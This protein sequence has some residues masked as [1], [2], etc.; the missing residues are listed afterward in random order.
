MIIKIDYREKTLKLLC[1]NELVNNK[2]SINIQVDS[3]DLPLGDAILCDDDGNE[4]LMIERKTLHDLAASI[5]DGRYKEQGY[6]LQLSTFHNHNIYY[7][8]EGSLKY[9][10]SYTRIDKKA[11]LSSMVSISHFKGFSLHRTNDIQESAEWIVQL[12]EKIGKQKEIPFYKNITQREI[13]DNTENTENTENIENIENTENTIQNND[14]YS[15]NIKRT[16]KNN[17]TP[18]NIGEIML[19]QIPNVSANTA[20]TIMREYKSIYN[21]IKC[22]KEDDNCLNNIKISSCLKEQEIQRKINK[23]T[24]SSIIKYLL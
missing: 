10:K 8:I 18:E 17:I 20:L 11:L 22:L 6:R 23:N 1:E 2:Y 13:I 24:V 5:C 16:K 4:I 12:A 14:C 21:L 19:S 7:L 3:V 9:Y 15:L